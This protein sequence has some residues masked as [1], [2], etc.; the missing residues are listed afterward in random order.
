MTV[1]DLYLLAGPNGAGK[2][3]F[4]DYALAA[5][6]LPF[7]NAD[8]IAA[9]E[10]PDDPM[11]YAYEASRR[12][13]EER[14]RLLADRRSVVTETVFS[15]PSKVDLVRTATE[16]GYLVH[17]R[18]LII[19]EDLAVAR[20]AQRVAEGGH[21]VPEEKVRKRHRRLYGHVADALRWAFD[22]R[23]FDSTG[24]SGENFVEVAR[25]R[26]DRLVGDHDYPTWAPDDL[27]R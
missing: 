10:S 5:T 24:A 26:F 1:P 3:T 2:T 15:H 7:V 18:V 4:Y 14:A 25:Y 27:P 17:L 12:A 11:A 16:A 22:T 20:V 6:G 21:D 23:V 8:R 9:D 13:A 19:P